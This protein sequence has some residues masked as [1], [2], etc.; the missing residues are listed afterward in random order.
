MNKSQ[1]RAMS[2]VAKDIIMV[3]IKGT[4][5]YDELLKLF[6]DIMLKHGIKQNTKCEGGGMTGDNFEWT[7]CRTLF[8]DT[9]NRKFEIESIFFNNSMPEELKHY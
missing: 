8:L 2:N 7:M 3:D 5:S 6:Y 1:I 4:E 9:A